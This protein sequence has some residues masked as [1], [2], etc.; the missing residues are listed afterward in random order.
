[1]NLQA[2]ASGKVGRLCALDLRCRHRALCRVHRRA[3]HQRAGEIERD[4]HVG[5]LVLDGLVRPDLPAELLPLFHIRHGVGQHA[6]AGAEQVRRRRER[7]QV[8]SLV[9]SLRDVV[10]LP[11]LDGKESAAGVDRGNLLA[12][13]RHLQPVGVSDV[14][15]LGDVGIKGVRSVRRSSNRPERPVG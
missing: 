7:R 1:V 14:H 4:A 8:E 9:R 10:H 2:D 12:D 11:G 6:L 13:R 5:Q 15:L 3:E